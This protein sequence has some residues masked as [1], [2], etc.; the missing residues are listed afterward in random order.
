MSNVTKVTK[1]LS[2]DLTDIPSDQHKEVKRRVGN[3]VVNEILRSVGNGKSPVEGER[4]EK[5]TKEYADKEHG[6]RR[7][8]ILELEGD[9]LSA[10]KAENKKGG[11]IEIGIKGSQAPKADG[12]NQI[13][14]EAKSWARETGRTQYKR[15]FIPDDK[16]KF[17]EPIRKGIKNILDRYRDLTPEEVLASV[18]EVTVGTISSVAETPDRVAVSVDDFFSDDVIEELLRRAIRARDGN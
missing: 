12:H 4:F 3:Y 6:G 15:R 16:Q 13:S 18:E 7:L 14:Q 11:G 10:L 2:L 5:L 8:P 1:L 17:I 9:M